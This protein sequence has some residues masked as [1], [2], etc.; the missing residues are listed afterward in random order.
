MKKKLIIL[1][2]VLIAIVGTI[3]GGPIV[4][5]KIN[6]EKCYVQIIED[7]EGNT[8]KAQKGGPGKYEYKLN[9]YDKNGNQVPVTFWTIKKLR[10][11]AYLSV[12]VEK[13]LNKDMN[14]INSYEEVTSEKLPEKVKEKLNVNK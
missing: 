12:Q 7:T 6:F 5:K 1:S 8:L 4:Y 13:P 9:A 14:Q 11:N 3:V 2:I 10:L